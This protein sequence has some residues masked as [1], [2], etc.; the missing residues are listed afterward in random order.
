MLEPYY[1]RKKTKALKR[2]MYRSGATT[3]GR[4]CG[5]CTACCT[6]MA[7][8]EFGKGMYRTCSHVSGQ[9]CS[10]Y[11]ERPR[12]CRVWSCQ[13]QLGEID[14]ERPDKSGVVINLGFRGGPHYEVFE[15]WEGAAAQPLLLE[16]LGKLALPVYVF[17]YESRGRTGLELQGH[18]TYTNNCPFGHGEPSS[19]TSLPVLP[20]ES[21]PQHA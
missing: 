5:G 18:R 2:L 13:W 20:E 8:K 3:L 17:D 19:R 9:G 7:V 11:Q 1:R 4:E 14:G 10:I 15:L 12:S 6:V 16:T 21:Q